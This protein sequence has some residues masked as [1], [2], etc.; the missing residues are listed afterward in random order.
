MKF[1]EQLQ[2]F[3]DV[4]TRIEQSWPYVLVIG[5]ALF[6]VLT[7]AGCT[8]G[9]KVDSPLART[10][11]TQGELFDPD[12]QARTWNQPPHGGIDEKSS[13]TPGCP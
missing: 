9:A 2:T 11:E 7:I 5:A 10:L 13:P 3:S 4:M 1:L 6:L 12:L 8:I